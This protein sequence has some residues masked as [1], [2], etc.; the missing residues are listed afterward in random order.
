RAAGAAQPALTEMEAALVSDPPISYRAI[1]HCEPTSGIINDIRAVGALVRRLDRGY[2][3]DAMSSFGAIPI[4]LADC[5]IDY[6]VSSANKCLEGV[7]GF[8]FVLARRA[9]LSG[10]EGW[11]R[12]VS[13]D[14]LAQWRELDA[15]GQFR[16]TP[17]T[18]ALLAFRQA[19]LEFEEEGGVPARAARYR[20][21]YET[22][23]AGMETM[24][25]EPYLRAEDR[26]Y[27]ITSFRYPTHAQFD[28]QKFYEGLNQLGQVIY[29]GKVSNADCF[30]IGHIGRIDAADVHALLGAIRMTLAGMGVSGE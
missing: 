30:R 20:S 10:T 12:S 14:L 29:P 21:N 19:L 17:P 23:L 7:P 28:F 22:L 3:V 16:F 8:S 15:S 4:D 26:G 6:L 25:F 24:G 9:T 27:I 18:H 5:H 2:I 13:L 1:D 11:A